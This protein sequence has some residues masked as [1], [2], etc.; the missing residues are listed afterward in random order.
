LAIPE[1]SMKR[2]QVILGALSAIALTIGGVAPFATAD[3]GTHSGIQ[4]FLLLQTSPDANGPQAV[5][6]TGPIHA[7]GKDVVLSDTLDRFVFPKGTVRIKHTPQ[8]SHDTFDPVTCFGTFTETGTYRVVGG[9]GA[10]DDVSGHGTYRVLASFVSC[11][12]TQPPSVFMLQANVH[13]PI[14]F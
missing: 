12:Q 2:R 14:S 8:A 10:Y 13:G 7:A 3:N 6:A 4:H 1:V 11:S 9:S 5:I